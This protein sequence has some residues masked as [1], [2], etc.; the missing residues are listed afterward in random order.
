MTHEV[1]LPGLNDKIAHLP[2]LVDG[3]PICVAGVWDWNE[4][5]QVM[6]LWRIYHKRAGA[7]FGPFYASIPLAEKGMRKALKE[8]PKDVWEHDLEWYQPQGWI[9]KWI[10]ANLGKTMDLV[11]AEWEKPKP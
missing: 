6:G 1:V 10:E 7:C 9:L 5:Y 8:I 2:I 4:N 3:G 11:G